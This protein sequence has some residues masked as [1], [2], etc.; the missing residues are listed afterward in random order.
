[1]PARCHLAE[2]WGNESVHGCLQVRVS[3]PSG[4]RIE[5][6][7]TGSRFRAFYPPIY[8]RLPKSRGGLVNIVPIWTDETATVT[9][10]S[11]Y[12]LA[13]EVLSCEHERDDLSCRISDM[14]AHSIERQEPAETQS[15]LR[16]RFPKGH[17]ARL[18]CK[19]KPTRSVLIAHRLEHHL[20]RAL[21]NFIRLVDCG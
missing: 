2:L 3:N 8:Y 7:G 17:E 13:W 10:R 11:H 19:D 15:P 21:R 16:A 5:L 18:N 20:S 14:R 4:S 12:V 6:T 9:M 1:M